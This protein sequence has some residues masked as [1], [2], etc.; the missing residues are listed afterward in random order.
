MNMT[1]STKLQDLKFQKVFDWH[2]IIHDNE[3]FIIDEWDIL[4]SSF[5]QAVNEINKEKIAPLNDWDLIPCHRF[6]ERSTL[7]H[8]HG[9][10]L[11]FHL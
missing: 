5:E 9:E 3:G 8:T 7:L 11:K 2:V 6:T 1:P 10:I 4:A